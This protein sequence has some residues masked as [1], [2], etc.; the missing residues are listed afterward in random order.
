M[1]RLPTNPGENVFLRLNDVLRR[2]YQQLGAHFAL[3]VR[4]RR[5]WRALSTD[6]SRHKVSDIEVSG[7]EN[8]NPLSL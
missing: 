6:F 5:D 3:E 1:T 7:N 4:S 2:H 8:K